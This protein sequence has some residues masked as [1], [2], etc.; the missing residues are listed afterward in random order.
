[1]TYEDVRARAEKN[2]QKL[3]KDRP[4]RW[5]SID[6]MN[7]EL[8]YAIVMSEDS[9]FFEH[10]GVNFDAMIGAALNNLRKKKYESGASTISQQVTKNIFLTQDKSLVRKLKEVIVTRR[11]ETRFTKN[12]I[13]ELYLNLAEFGPDVYGIQAA[14]SHYFK[15]KPSEINAAEGAFLALM[16]PSPRK[17]HYS[18]FENQNITLSKKKKLRRILGDMLSQELISPKQYREYVRYD[19]FPDEDR[20]P[21]QIRK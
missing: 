11:V 20:T 18:V 17:F 12:E 7:R 10:E 19:Y 4:L 3:V 8:I 14:A 2:L 6:H 1:M 16:L 13:L 9:T 5:V 21:A 15:K